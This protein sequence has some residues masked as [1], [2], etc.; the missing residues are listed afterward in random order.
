MRPTSISCASIQGSPG[1]CSREKVSRPLTRFVHRPL[2]RIPLIPGLIARLAVRV[3][4]L[5]LK[6][7]FRS[8]RT[9][10]RFFSG[11]RSL[12]YWSALRDNGWL[13]FSNRLLVLC[14]HAI[15]DQSDDPVLA[16]YGVPPEQFADQLDALTRRGFSFVS[17]AQLAAYIRS[18]GPLPRRPVLLTFDDGYADLVG[19]AQEVLRP[20]GIETLVFVVTGSKS[21]TNEWD[22]D[23]G[24]KT[25]NLL[26]A[27]ERIELASLG[28]EIGSH[29]R[30]HREMPLLERP[31]QMEEAANSAEDLAASG[32]RRPRFFA[33]PFG[34]S[35]EGSK[36]AVRKAGY[37]AAFGCRSDW[38]K[39]GNDLF[40]LPRVI[41]LASDSGWR[42][43]MKTRV[44]R[45]FANIAW[46]RQ[47]IGNRVRKI[48]SRARVAH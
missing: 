25:I 14:Y 48:G 36:D 38:V 42:F 27:E 34:F 32:L 10:A 47:G 39:R 33:Y 19:L 24:A 35:D 46:L 6:T 15:E 2:A 16:P 43:S 29:S 40:E 9:V 44:P 4:D 5:A 21:G 37:V 13:P 3:A 7:P 11:A 1:S 41:V 22:Q 30:T 31:E 28:V 26:S 23:Y 17:P 8:S 20:R 18:N 45:L 12:A